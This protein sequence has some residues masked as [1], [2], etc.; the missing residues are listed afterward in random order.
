M[1]G[2]GLALNL[3]GNKKALMGIA[4]AI[5]ISVVGGYIW[6]LKSD[7][8][9][10]E[11]DK[12]ELIQEIGGLMVTIE[13]FE[14]AIANQNKNVLELKRKAI[15]ADVR[16]KK[17]VKAASVLRQNHKKEISSLSTQKVPQQCER[18]VDWLQEKAEDELKW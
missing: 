3:L 16:L 15:D 8:T 7:I 12:V 1:I 6:Y 2:A 10:L 14:Y 17:A 4:L 5:A 11:E 13:N 18:A 9:S